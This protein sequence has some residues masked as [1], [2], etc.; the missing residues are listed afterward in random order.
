MAKS[1]S[2]D[3]QLG[4]DYA[5]ENV[6]WPKTG[7]VNKYN[8]S[9]QLISQCKKIKWWLVWQMHHSFIVDTIKI[10]IKT[11]S[12]F[13]D[14]RK[15]NAKSNNNKCKR[16]NNWKKPGMPTLTIPV[17]HSYFGS[18]NLSPALFLR[19]CRNSRLFRYTL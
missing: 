15:E 14:Q 16:N 13:T 10:C 4:S 18:F 11:T 2:L 3:V 5:S 7:H 19:S 6:E 1:S 17:G 8:L 9:I 12:R